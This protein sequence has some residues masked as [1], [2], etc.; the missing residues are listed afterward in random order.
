MASYPDA[1][2]LAYGQ[3]TTHGD[4]A[5]TTFNSPVVGMATAPGGNGYWL[6]TAAGNVYTYGAAVSFGGVEHEKIIAPIVGIVAMPTGM[7]YWLYALNGQI[8]PFGDAGYYGSA[9]NLNLHGQI[10]GM[11]TTSDGQG[12]WMVSSTGR[13]ANFGDAPALGSLTAKDAGSVVGIAASPTSYGFWLVTG[14]GGVY[15]F[16][17]V[18]T[19]GSLAKTPIAGWVNGMVAT[20]DGQGYWLVN[21]NGDVYHYGDAKFY[22]DNLGAP[23]TEVVTQIIVDPAGGGYWLLE[24]DAFPTAFTNPASHRIVR[25]AASQIKPDPDKGYFCNPYGPCEAWCA[26]FATWVWRQSGVYIP[27]YAFVGSI[28][29]WAAYHTHVEPIQHPRPGDIVLYGTGPQNVNTAVHAGIVAQV[30]PDGAIDTIEGDAGPAP[31]GKYNVIINGP[32]MPSDSIH[33]NGMPIFGFAQP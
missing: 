6:A 13:V 29:Y 11:A 7:G 19:Y 24:P 21:A 9:H 26:L 16:G 14:G 3:A 2:V 12:Y 1:G 22:G 27:S 32:F 25:L 23:R 17:P 28:Y 30:W 15:P 4:P 8:Y 18:S 5:K 33:Y 10:V 31:E 20:P